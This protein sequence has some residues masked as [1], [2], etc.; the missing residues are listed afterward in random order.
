MFKIPLHKTKLSAWVMCLSAFALLMSTSCEE[1]DLEANIIFKQVEN[2]NPS[3]IHLYYESPDP[4]CGIRKMYDITAGT[5][6]GQITLVAPDVE[7][8]HI[9]NL[10][11]DAD[12]NHDGAEQDGV[13]T[14]IDGQ[15]TAK[16][17]PPRT[18]V[19]NFAEVDTTLNDYKQLTSTLTLESIGKTNPKIEFIHV[20]RILK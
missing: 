9:L 12:T 8:I 2:T 17:I 5:K 10:T 3:D 16:V 7:N 11:N 19:I 14:S 1:K 15:W 18:V 20:Q 6:G 4:S 13:W